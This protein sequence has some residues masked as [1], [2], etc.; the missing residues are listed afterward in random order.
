MFFAGSPGR[1][2]PVDLARHNWRVH[3]GSV[4]YHKVRGGATSP[5]RSNSRHG[6]VQTLGRGNC[7]WVC[8]RLQKL[9][10]VVRLLV[11]IVA[12]VLV[13]QC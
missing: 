7:G 6:R 11:R 1:G 10:C 5:H 8:G 3:C 13:L 2:I 12:S 4:S 9:R